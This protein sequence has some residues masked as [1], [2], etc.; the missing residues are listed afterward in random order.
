VISLRRISACALALAASL[1]FAGPAAAIEQPAGAQKNMELKSSFPEAK[2]ATAI[3]FLQYGKGAKQRDVMIATGRFGL[4]TYDL[5]DPAHPRKLDTLDNEALRLTGDPPTSFPR[6][7]YWQNEDM[8]VDQHRKLVFMARD[9]RSFGGTTRSD[10]SVAGVYIVD[11]R[12]PQDIKLITF[13]QLPTGHT[14][15]CINDCRY[16]WTGG[17]ASSASQLA[18][19]PGGRPIIVTDVRD[20][21]NPK[22]SPQPIDLFRN[23]GQTA[24][25]HDVQV[26]SAGI[27]WV[28]GQG[29]VRGYWTEGRHYDPVKGVTRE[30]TATDPVPYGGG[31]FADDATP[32]QFMHNS[33]RPVGRTLADGPVPGKEKPGSLIMATEEADAPPDCDGLAQFTIASLEGSYDGQA[34]R[35]TPADK[36]RLRTVGSWSPHGQEG[37]AVNDSIYCSAHYFDVQ[38]RFVAY[39]WYDQGT[40]ILDVSDPTNPVQVAYYR[41]DDGVSWAPYFHRGYVYVADHGRGIDVL[42]VSGRAARAASAGRGVV[43]PRASKRH[44]RLVRKASRGLKPDPQLGWLCPLTRY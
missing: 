21:K 1:G 43:A 16:L 30:A 23:D 20:P 31:A 5:A 24:Y 34:W 2:Y 38:K 28:S 25:S 6:V 19:W 3:N 35:S 12:D 42:K 39:S 44:L 29:G 40:R 22:T 33:A 41:P 9:P 15:T 8:D 14:T 11:L 17:P 37:T 7:T 4:I 18:A 27:A 32:S 26:D 10:T 36:F 13:H